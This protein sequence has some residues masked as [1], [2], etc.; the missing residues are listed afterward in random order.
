MERIWKEATMDKDRHNPT[1][2]WWD[3]GKLTT[4]DSTV[5]AHA[6]IRT[7][8]RLHINLESHQFINL[9]GN[10]YNNNSFPILDYIILLTT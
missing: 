9:H 2:T 8:L 3:W 1:F 4:R 7:G 6:N 5:T 10:A